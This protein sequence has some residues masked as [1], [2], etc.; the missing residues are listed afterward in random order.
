[1]NT[2]NRNN[3]SEIGVARKWVKKELKIKIFINELPNTLNFVYEV[4]IIKDI[5]NQL[6]NSES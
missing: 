2:V 4:S 1:M 3:T 5:L 6:L